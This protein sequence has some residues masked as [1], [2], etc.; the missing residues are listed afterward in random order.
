MT[1]KKVSFTNS[2]VIGIS[3]AIAMLPGISG[4]GCNNLLL[5]VELIEQE[6]L[7]FFS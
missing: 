6:L 7:V 3:Q 5:F 2:V 4:S 1:D